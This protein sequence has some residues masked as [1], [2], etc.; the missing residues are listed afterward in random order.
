MEI[1]VTNLGMFLPCD[2]G[3]STARIPGTASAHWLHCD[4]PDLRLLCFW[5]DGIDESLETSFLYI[6]V[7]IAHC[8]VFEIHK[9]KPNKR[10]SMKLADFLQSD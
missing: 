10:D 7:V 5:T 4:Q 9:D 6:V 3:K 2:K 8:C 1:L